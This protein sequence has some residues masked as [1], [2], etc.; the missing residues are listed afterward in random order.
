MLLL[1][2]TLGAQESPEI[3][4][5]APNSPGTKIE[6]LS[7]LPMRE[8]DSWLY[9]QTDD[10]QGD[11]ISTFVS[12]ETSS[13]LGRSD[14]RSLRIDSSDGAAWREGSAA[15]RGLFWLEEIAFG[16]RRLVYPNTLHLLPSQV[17]T[18][19]SYLSSGTYSLIVDEARLSTGAVRAKVTVGDLVDISVPAGEFED[20]LKLVF[21]LQYE[22]ESTDEASDSSSTRKLTR[23]YARGV[24]VIREETM[25]PLA[26]PLAEKA[27]KRVLVLV[28]AS[29]GETLIPIGEDSRPEIP[30]TELLEATPPRR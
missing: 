24:G 22:E 2:G 9:R 25:S 23:W 5:V 10:E 14:L 28:E 1:A 8:G 30:G 19:A 7:Y 18:G 26:A 13:K 11:Q 6:L 27:T 3:E 17:E 20:S 4:V 12:E 29:V 21:E 16:G 15:G